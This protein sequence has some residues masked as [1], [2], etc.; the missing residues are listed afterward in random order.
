MDKAS[1]TKGCSM[2]VNILSNIDRSAEF[3]SELCST[4]PSSFIERYCS[5]LGI[6]TE[7]TMLSKF[8][9]KKIEQK[10]IISDN[11]PHAVAAGIIFFVSQTCGLQISKNDITIKCGVSEVTINKCCKKM[12]SIKG[13]LIPKCILDK[14]A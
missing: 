10:N 6:N 4:T 2:A 3:Q 12:E 5:S 9:A 13:D 11:T 7:L 8:I 14:Y 1:A